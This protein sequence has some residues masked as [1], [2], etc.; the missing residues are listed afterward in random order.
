MLKAKPAREVFPLGECDYVCLKAPS[1]MRENTMQGNR[2]WNP[3]YREEL[4]KEST[5]H[6]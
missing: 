2:L 5:R 3:H 1:L 6:G 4:E